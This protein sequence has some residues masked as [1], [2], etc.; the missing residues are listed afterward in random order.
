MSYLWQLYSPGGEARYQA[1]LGEDVLS[2][3][4]TRVDKIQ[5]ER[6][7]TRMSVVSAASGLWSARVHLFVRL[8]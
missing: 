2:A 5:E 8:F 3:S 4:D 7:T 6:T 1:C